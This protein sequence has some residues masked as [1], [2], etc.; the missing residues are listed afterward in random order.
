MFYTELKNPV[1]I[2]WKQNQELKYEIIKI[3]CSWKHTTF[4]TMV[5]LISS[6]VI[7]TFLKVEPSQT[8]TI[9]RKK[10]EFPLQYRLRIHYM[11]PSIYCP[12]VAFSVNIKGWVLRNPYRV[13]QN[14]NKYIF[15]G[16]R[17]LLEANSWNAFYF[18]Q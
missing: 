10:I 12:F 1:W 4:W 8:E 2:S 16:E 3:W 7:L 6:K 18:F 9:T 17:S 11:L 14:K 15:I 5:E 13:H